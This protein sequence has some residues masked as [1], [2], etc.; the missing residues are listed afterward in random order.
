MSLAVQEIDL[1]KLG[2]ARAAWDQFPAIVREELNAA[3]S[4]ADLLIEREVRERTPSGASKGGASGLKGSLYGE[5]TVGLDNVIGVVASSLPYAEPVELGTRP[6]FPPVEPLIDWVI[7]KLNVPEEQAPGVAFLVARKIARVGTPAA[8]MFRDGF[9]A[10][11]GQVEGIFTRA[12]E[13]IAA[14]CAGALGGRA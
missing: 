9:A 6:H 8:H 2:A 12:N 5:E 14:R 7:A 4:E 3:M 1:I 13:R 11:Q 10:V